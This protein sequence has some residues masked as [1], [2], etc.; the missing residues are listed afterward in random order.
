MVESCH[1][2]T[3]PRIIFPILKHKLNLM[4]RHIRDPI[5]SLSHLVGAIL[6]IIGLYLLLNRNIAGDTVYHTISFSV[7]G[8]A[9]IILYSTSALYHWLPSTNKYLPLLRKIDHIMIFV[10]IAASNTPICLVSI[11]GGWGWSIFASVWAITVGGFIFKLFWMNA[12]RFL[13]TSIYLL[14]GWMIVIGIYPLTKV[15]QMQGIMLLTF[16]GILYSI[17]AVIYASKKPNPLPGTFGF[18]E[19]F[20]L[21]IMAGSLSHYLMM[22]YYV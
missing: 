1:G 11:R 8:I 19:I 3:L 15:M 13:Y 20:H 14:M 16:G 9:M 7:F 2:K 18:H 6:S 10:F 12:P 17:G 22:Y 21:F 5:S 4:V